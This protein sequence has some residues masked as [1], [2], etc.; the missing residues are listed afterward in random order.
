MAAKIT[1]FE[2]EFWIE[3]GVITNPEHPDLAAALMRTGA[4]LKMDSSA[5]VVD[6]DEH[7]ARLLCAEL[8]GSIIENHPAPED[9]SRIF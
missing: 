9:K 5:Y 7:L 6:A 3:N 8:D 2:L 1:L 4:R